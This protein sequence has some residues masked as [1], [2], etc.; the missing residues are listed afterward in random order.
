MKTRNVDWQNVNQPAF[1][2]WC[3]AAIFIDGQ[4]LHFLTAEDI[5]A[6][7]P[8][9]RIAGM[10][11]YTGTAIPPAPLR[12]IGYHCGPRPSSG[13]ASVRRCSLVL[14]SSGL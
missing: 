2:P 5:D 10:E 1:E 6:F 12:L 9:H 11:V 13:K 14:L 4:F 7:V 3:D 8:P